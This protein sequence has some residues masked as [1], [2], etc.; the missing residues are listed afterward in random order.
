MLP[1]RLQFITDAPTVDQTVAQARQALDGGCRWVQVRM[2][3]ADRPTLRQAL[4]RVRELC[5]NKKATLI[6]DDDVELCRQGFADGV[7]LGQ[8]DMPV[9]DA[10]RILG[11]D[12]IIGLT[13]NNMDHARAALAQPA[14]Y[15]G[16]GPWRF[17]GTKANLAPVLGPQGVAEIV[18]TLRAG[19]FERPI[20]VIGGV[21]AADVAAIRATGADGVAV[22][23]AISRAPDPVEA[24]QTFVTAIENNK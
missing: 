1:V 13:V 17:T 21:T 19:G 6:V 10:R 11:P 22:A 8:T 14:D 3:G 5:A 7:H 4:E 12:K 20:V 24:T 2:K 16:L 15:I 23:G 18:A 9:A